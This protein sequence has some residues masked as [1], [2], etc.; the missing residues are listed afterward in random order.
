[1]RY[2]NGLTEKLSN[3]TV[4][5]KNLALNLFRRKPTPIQQGQ[6][7][8]DYYDSAFSGNPD[9]R[10][11]FTKSPYYFL[12]TVIV[13]RLRNAPATYLLEIGCGPGQLASAMNAAG[14]FD[15]YLGIDFSDVAIDFARDANPTLSF[16]L[17][18]ALTTE[19]LETETY[20]TI[21]TTE[22]LEHVEEELEVIG[23]IRPGTRVLG[24]VPNFPYVSH[25]RHFDTAEQVYERYSDDFRDFRVTE[26]DGVQ[27]DTK[28]FLMD[29]V[30]A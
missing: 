17:D 22:F 19:L 12:W 25:V 6:Q 14:V 11:P 26:I 1:M 15:R 29:G 8:S 24:T 7:G 10:E 9:W 16:A 21:V 2:A 23:K 18:N 30:K 20:D 4:I 13:D 28:F 27:P 3:D 5:V